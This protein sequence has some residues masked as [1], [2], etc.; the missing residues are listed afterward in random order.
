LKS[1]YGTDPSGVFAFTPDTIPLNG[2]R[3]G[4]AVL[5][6]QITFVCDGNKS[7]GRIK[8]GL[9][10]QGVDNAREGLLTGVESNFAVK[11]SGK[12]DMSSKFHS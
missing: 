6:S 9:T 8:I 4:R 11:V 5:Q 2:P 1:F 10:S 12:T 7:R 3:E